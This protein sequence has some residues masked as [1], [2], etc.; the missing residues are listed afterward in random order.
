[1]F[2]VLCSVY[3]V[4]KRP[5]LPDGQLQ[6]EP[7][8]ASHLHGSGIYRVNYTLDA[9]PTVD[10]QPFLTAYIVEVRVDGETPVYYWMV[11]LSLPPPSLPPSLSLP[12]SPSL[13]H[14]HVYN[15]I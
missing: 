5:P 11:C 13:P 4:R 15:A 7:F 12:P 1:M 14:L 6:L 10:V 2:D 8:H 3:V 9:V